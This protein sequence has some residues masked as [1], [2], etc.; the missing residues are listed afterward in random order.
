M[1]QLAKQA[2]EMLAKHVARSSG[3]KSLV[4]PLDFTVEQV[5]FFIDAANYEDVKD[6]L[7]FT[8]FKRQ[9]GQANCVATREESEAYKAIWELEVTETCPYCKTAHTH[10][11]MYLSPHCTKQKCIRAHGIA[12]V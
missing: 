3:R 12:H 1:S 6:T 8:A 5:E 2:Q 11:L 10:A 9:L 4:K 7:L